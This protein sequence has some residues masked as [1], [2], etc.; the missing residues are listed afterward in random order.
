MFLKRHFPQIS[1]KF[2]IFTVFFLNQCGRKDTGFTFLRFKSH[3]SNLLIFDNFFRFPS[4]KFEMISSE[5]TFITIYFIN[6][7]FEGGKAKRIF[8]I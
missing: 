4:A 6:I 8:L 5:I 3:L 2:Y 7:Y 1:K